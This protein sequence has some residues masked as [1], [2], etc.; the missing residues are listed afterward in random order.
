MVLMQDRYHEVHP[1][2]YSFQAS[3]TSLIARGPGMLSAAA[4]ALCPNVSMVP[5]IAGDITRVAFRFGLVVDQVC[6][7]LEVSPDEINAAGAWIYCV[8]GVDPHEAQ[9]AVTCFNVEKVDQLLRFQGSFRLVLTDI[10]GIC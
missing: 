6:R 9:E 10:L 2:E 8:Y 3:D 1:L 4:I 5:S 7:S